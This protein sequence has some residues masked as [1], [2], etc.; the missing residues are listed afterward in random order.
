[1]PAISRSEGGRSAC[2]R[3]AS[4]HRA[5]RHRWFFGSRGPRLPP[6]PGRAFRPWA[7]RARR[8]G[9]SSGTR[10]L[11][12]AGRNAEPAPIL[13]AAASG[14]PPCP[15]AVSPASAA[16]AQPQRRACGGRR[17]IR[18][19]RSAGQAG[20]QCLMAGRMVWLAV[21]PFTRLGAYSQIWF[22]RRLCRFCS[23]N[24]EGVLRFLL[25]N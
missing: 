22:C 3:K 5:A 25:R 16:F 19:A 23:Q 21:S 24:F 1:M 17:K 12:S 15:E 14:T 4:P 10:R 6:N 20:A 8:I 18:L 9:G 11:D 7:A 13:R 2:P